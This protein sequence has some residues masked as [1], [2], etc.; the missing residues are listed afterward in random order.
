M[1]LSSLV[2]GG[3]ASKKLSGRGCHF[4]HGC[5]TGQGGWG[6]FVI[7]VGGT[8]AD[9]EPPAGYWCAASTPRDISPPQHPTGV[10]PSR[11]QLPNLPYA[12]PRGGVVHAFRPGHWYTLAL[13]V[14]DSAPLTTRGPHIDTS[15]AGTALDT[16]SSLSSA[17]RL[18]FS[19]GGTQG[20]EG[21]PWAE[22]WF[23]ESVLEE[24]DAPRTIARPRTLVFDS[25]RRP[26]ETPAFASRMRQASGTSSRGGLRMEARMPHGASWCICRMHRTPTSRRRR[27]ALS[28]RSCRSSSIL[29][30]RPHRPSAA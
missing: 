24:L 14:G 19:R 5:W 20:A 22:N 27:Q 16:S 13:E 30:A 11:E 12:A 28:R 29:V 10:A 18:N 4:G 6:E 2:R 25:S 26:C 15:G 1:Q 21:L 8:C 17:M 23:I 9:R 3:R 7:G